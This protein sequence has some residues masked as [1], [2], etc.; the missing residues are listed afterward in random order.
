MYTILDLNQ[1]SD[2]DFYAFSVPQSTVAA[3]AADR[4]MHAENHRQEVRQPVVQ[5]EPDSVNDQA[6]ITKPPVHSNSTT[7]MSCATKNKPIIQPKRIRKKVNSTL[8]ITLLSTLLFLLVALYS[9]L[10]KMKTL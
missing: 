5:I 8:I 2:D 7:V 9:V 6:V 3:P 10:N 1:S 4:V